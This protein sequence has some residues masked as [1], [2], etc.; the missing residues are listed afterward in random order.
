MN[1]ERKFTPEVVLYD[2]P[3]VSGESQTSV[4]TATTAQFEMS[5]DDAAQ[6]K[7]IDTV[8]KAVIHGDEVIEQYMH[9][10]EPAYETS[11]SED[12]CENS[13]NEP[14]DGETNVQK[15]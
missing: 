4:S 13:S 11:S 10:I 6:C 12:R 14:A 3:S 8:F 7:T 9:Q 5:M 1:T 2:E 15:K